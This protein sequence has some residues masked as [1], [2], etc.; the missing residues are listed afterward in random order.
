MP[1]PEQDDH[2]DPKNGEQPDEKKAAGSWKEVFSYKSATVVLSLLLAVNA[3]IFAGQ[4]FLFSGNSSLPSGEVTLGEFHYLGSDSPD[5]RIRRID[6][7]VHVHLLNKVDHKGRTLL[8]LHQ[9]KVEQNIEELLRQAHD[10]DFDDPKLTELKRQIQ[11][12]INQSLDQR[13]IEEVLITDFTADRIP[14][15]PST[16]LAR[17]KA[18]LTDAK[19]ASDAK[20]NQKSNTDTKTTTQPWKAADWREASPSQVSSR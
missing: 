9:F 1:K 17:G 15:T 10:A 13:V 11:E 8:K 4:K 2:A 3:A 5:A 6:F 14:Q 12:T 19:S 7:G 18:S 16:E 20:S